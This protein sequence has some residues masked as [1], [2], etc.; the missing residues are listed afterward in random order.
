MDNYLVFLEPFLK[1]MG[2]IFVGFIGE[3]VFIG[4]AEKKV[5]FFDALYPAF[6]SNLLKIILIV[7][8]IEIL[9]AIREGEIYF[10][11]YLFT[12]LFVMIFVLLLALLIRLFLKVRLNRAMKISLL[13]NVLSFLL[14]IG[15]IYLVF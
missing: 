6:V 9:N 13:A 8:F 12:F 5:S 1:V 14:M 15:T 11:P 3:T 10:D 7:P 4:V 2:V